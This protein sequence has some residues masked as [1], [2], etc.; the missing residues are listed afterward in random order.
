MSSML[1]F[2]SNLHITLS[3]ALEIRLFLLSAGRTQ[4]YVQNLQNFVTRREY[5]ILL[6]FYL[7]VFVNNFMKCFLLFLLFL[8]FFSLFF[9]VVVPFL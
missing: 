2:D 8:F 7:T 5:F 4:T 1:S 9:L 3:S 6:N